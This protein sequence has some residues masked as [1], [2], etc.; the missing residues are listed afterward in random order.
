MPDAITTHVT[1]VIALSNHHATSG[2]LF[3][4]HLTV[5]VSNSSL[6][7][8]VIR[9]LRERLIDIQDGDILFFPNAA[10]GYRFTRVEDDQAMPL[11]LDYGVKKEK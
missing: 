9:K 3:N 7:T 8:S 2:L 11:S 4:D 6:A 1:H 10:D 5:E